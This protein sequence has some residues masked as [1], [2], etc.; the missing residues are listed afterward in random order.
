MKLY[1]IKQNAINVALH[2]SKQYESQFSWQIELFKL[3]W[4]FYLLHKNLSKALNI[5]DLCFLM[6]FYLQMLILC[7]Q[8]L[9]LLVYDSILFA[10]GELPL[11]YTSKSVSRCWG[12]MLNVLEKNCINS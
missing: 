11:F 5:D 6:Y 7:E 9:Y 4:N 1:F 3:S 8:L 12:V 2:K 10:K